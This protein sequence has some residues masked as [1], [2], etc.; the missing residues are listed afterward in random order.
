MLREPFAGQTQ[1]KSTWE[2]LVLCISAVKELD[3]S[4]EL[5]LK[6]TDRPCQALYIA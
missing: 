5:F 1:G 3:T 2:T 6:P 4:A